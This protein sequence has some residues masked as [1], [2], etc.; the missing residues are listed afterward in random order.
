[1]ATQKK[2]DILLVEDTALLAK[3]YIQFLRNEP[4]E[5][6]HVETGVEALSVIGSETPEAILLDLELP[7]MT[8]IDILEKIGGAQNL[9][10]PIIMITAHGSINIAVEAMRLGAFDFIVKPFNADRLIVTLRNAMDR[11]K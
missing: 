4:Y 10:C 9:P 11:Q 1:M 5:V 2:R 8:G 7:D 3:S 6:T